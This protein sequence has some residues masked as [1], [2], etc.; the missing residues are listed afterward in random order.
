MAVDATGADCLVGSLSLSQSALASC[1]ACCPL[2]SAVVRLGRCPGSRGFAAR[3]RRRRGLSPAAT[4]G[5]ALIA[6]TIAETDGR[7][8]KMTTSITARTSAHHAS[9][10]STPLE[11]LVQEE[12]ALELLL[13]RDHTLAMTTGTSFIDACIRRARHSLPRGKTCGDDVVT[14]MLQAYN[15]ADLHWA[16]AFGLQTQ[17]SDGCSYN[18]AA[19]PDPSRSC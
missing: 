9:M 14:E 18:S 8:A 19:S 1:L 16:G 12:V 3:G 11:E 2:G 5:K 7:R 10:F 15:S 13:R 17:S 4:G 6:R